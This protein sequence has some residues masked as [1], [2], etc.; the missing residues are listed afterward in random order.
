[1]CCL[2]HKLS[3][4]TLRAKTPFASANHYHLQSRSHVPQRFNHSTTSGQASAFTYPTRNFQLLYNILPPLNPRLYP[5]NDYSILVLQNPTTQNI[6][7]EQYAAF[8]YLC[9]AIDEKHDDK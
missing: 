6:Q 2:N 1:M 4:P 5:N 8:V 3:S 7:S 9:Q